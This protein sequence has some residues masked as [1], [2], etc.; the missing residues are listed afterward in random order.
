MDV[1]VFGAPSSV[2]F[3]GWCIFVVEKVFGEVRKV[4]I[5]FGGYINKR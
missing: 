2:D 5:V 1:R 3:V 4:M